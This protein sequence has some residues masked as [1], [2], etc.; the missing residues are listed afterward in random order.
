[1][2]QMGVYRSYKLG[3]SGNSF[4]HEFGKR[5]E[6][7]LHVITN[8][9]AE[10]ININSANNGLY[11]EKDEKAT[12]LYLDGKPFKSV[13]EFTAFEEVK[14]EPEK[15]EEEGVN[16]SNMTKAELIAFAKEHGFEID[17]TSKKEDIIQAIKEQSEN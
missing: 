17:A 5:L 1:M 15:T 3:R 2:S 10:S 9:Y 6:R 14:T 13:K 12:K 16:L 4:S 8:D 11:Y 7:D